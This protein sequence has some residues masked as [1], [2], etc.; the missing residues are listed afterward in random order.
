MILTVRCIPKVIH[1]RSANRSPQ[2]KKRCEVTVISAPQ[3]LCTYAT[4][5]LNPACWNATLKRAK[6][7]EVWS[8]GASWCVQV[9]TTNR[10]PSITTAPKSQPRSLRSSGTQHAPSLHWGNNITECRNCREQ[11]TRY[12]KSAIRNI[13]NSPTFS[14]DRLCDLVVRVPGYTTEMYCAS[15]EVRTE[16]IYVM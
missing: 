2:I 4:L 7:I 15:C 13:L 16:F 6:S 10:P 9:W 3:L 5:Q 1:N 14:S 11:E 12:I 8:E